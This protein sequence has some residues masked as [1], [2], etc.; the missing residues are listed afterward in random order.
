[1][2]SVSII[3]S[4]SQALEGGMLH[5]E[6]ETT[7]H[8]ESGQQSTPTSVLESAPEEPVPYMDDLNALAKAS[9]RL[10]PGTNG[11]Y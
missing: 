6:D 8:D 10:S 5:P 1:M 11:T 3:A 7:H 9:Y 4:T 2:A